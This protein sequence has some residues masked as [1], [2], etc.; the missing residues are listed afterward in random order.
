[1][2]GDA[3]SPNPKPMQFRAWKPMRPR[4]NTLCGYI[5][6]SVPSIGL[7]LDDL[8]V[9]EMGSRRWVSLPAR[10]IIDRD[11]IALRDE[12]NK[13][14]YVANIKWLSHAISERFSERV[15]ALLLQHYPDALDHGGAS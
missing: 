14:R 7:N 9:H 11:G 15:I 13:I 12:K 6:I 4:R 2:W 8:G 5:E 10:P 3:L 1:M